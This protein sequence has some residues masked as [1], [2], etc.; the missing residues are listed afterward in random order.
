MDSAS[1]APESFATIESNLIDKSQKGDPD[2]LTE[3]CNHYLPLVYRRVRFSIPVEDAEDVTQEIF[4]ALVRKIKTFK[5][6]ARFSTWLYTITNRKIADYYRKNNSK[7]NHFEMSDGE[8]ETLSTPSTDTETLMQTTTV[9]ANFAKLPD[10]YKEII[11]L[12]LIDNLG[13]Q[14]IAGELGLSYEAAKSLFR[15]AIAMLQ[16][17]VERE[18]PIESPR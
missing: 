7:S 1:P 12:R 3:I 11:I 2:A 8:I 14:E 4:I 16:T 6:D 17:E 10:Q 13:F 15:R 9:M 5:G 18:I